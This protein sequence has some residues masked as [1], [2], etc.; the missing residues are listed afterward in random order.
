MPA[1]CGWVDL[2]VLGAKSLV[3]DEFVSQFVEHHSQC[4]GSVEGN[5]YQV[6]AP[7]LE[8]RVCYADPESNNYI[9]V[10]EATFTKVGIQL[11][12]TDF[13]VAVLKKYEIAPSQIHP[14]SWGFIKGFEVICRE[15]GFPTS[16]KVFH[17]L[18][19]LTKP[20]SKDKQQWLFFRANQNMKVFEM[21][22]ESVR[23]FKTLYFKVLPHSGTTP[24]WVNKVGKSRFPLSWNEGWLD[25]KVDREELSESELL[26]VDTLTNCW[27]V[28]SGKSSVYDKFKAHLLNKSKKST[29]IVGAGSGS[30][31]PSSS[32][33]SALISS[34]IPDSGSTKNTS[35]TPSPSIQSVQDVD[36]SSKEPLPSQKRKAPEPKYGHINSKEFDYL[37][38]AQEYLLCGNSRIP[39][40]GENFLKNLEVVT[41]SSID[42]R[43]A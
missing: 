10:Y 35:T 32:D 11:P 31:K 12:F 38:F 28:M 20:F 34:A 24:F 19:K 9:F 37:G 27:E 23:D 4:L 36:N 5:R 14:N 15:F 26:F 42:E 41:R 33:Q 7:G 16:M 30:S 43:S 8:D 25:I 3:D 2:A 29:K 13:E 40:D 39:M 18:F 1:G 17:H 21:F 22:E 6:V